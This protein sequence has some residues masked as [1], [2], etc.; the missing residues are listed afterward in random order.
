[1]RRAHEPPELGAPLDF[2]RRLWELNHAIER[3]SSKM[4]RTIGVTAQQRL[5][6]RCVGKL[7]GIGA[8]ELAALLHLDRGTVSAS[9]RRLTDRG[10]MRRTCDPSDGR[11]VTLVL[12]ASG[13]TLDVA[14]TGTVEHAVDSLLRQTP[15]KEVEA[16]ALV[17]SR[18][19]E[20]LRTAHL[21]DVPGAQRPKRRAGGARAT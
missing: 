19:A 13:R 14:A 11:R 7:P 18:L 20:L 1:M 10:L 3:L 8:S 6:L 16:T 17:L 15:D 21:S 9:L 2:L 12:T 4:E 5:V